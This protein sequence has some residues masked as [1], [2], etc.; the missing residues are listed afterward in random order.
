MLEQLAASFNLYK[1]T[2]FK[3]ITFEVNSA[4]LKMQ[5][6]R[7]VRQVNLTNANVVEV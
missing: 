7:I 3:E 5:I 4:I 6:N 1:E 2:G